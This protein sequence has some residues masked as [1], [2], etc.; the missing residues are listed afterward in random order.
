[1]AKDDQL[2]DILFNIKFT[3]KQMNKSA[4]TTEK[5]SEKEKLQVK[6]ALESGNPEAAR[7]YAENA[8]RKKNESLNYLRLA[9][10]L[11]AAASRIQT[12]VQMQ[13]V[14]KSMKSTV[15]GMDKILTSMD[16][17]KIS[18]VM[19][20]FE[21]QVG[22]L[23]VNLGVMDAAFESTSAGTVPVGEVDTLMEQVAAENNIDISNR[24]ASG[25]QGSKLSMPEKKQDITEDDI[26][27][28]L[29]ALQ[30]L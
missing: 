16:P 23:D 22:T 2:Y 1:M 15:K 5:A 20:A 9:S 29:K 7:I 14:T 17:M 30:A 27:E 11:D 13:D 26:S 4:K 8:I 10:R 6:K 25:P 21:Q 24:L 19:D 12:A 18:K 28:R 3:S